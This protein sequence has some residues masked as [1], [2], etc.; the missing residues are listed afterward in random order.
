MY[1]IDLYMHYSTAELMGLG[2]NGVLIEEWVYRCWSE[3][4]HLSPNML[5]AF[6]ELSDAAILMVS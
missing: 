4:F 5:M 1:T 3:D 6:L 2:V